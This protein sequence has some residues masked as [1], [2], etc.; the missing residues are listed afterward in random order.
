MG[1][2]LGGSPLEMIHD[3]FDKRREGQLHVVIKIVGADFD[4]LLSLGSSVKVC[5]VIQF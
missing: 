4:I 2:I 1:N 3:H 5:T